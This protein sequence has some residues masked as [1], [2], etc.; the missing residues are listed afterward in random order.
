M[1]T[2]EW[3]ED[4]ADSWRDMLMILV[5]YCYMDDV[6]FGFGIVSADN[7]AVVA[8]RNIVTRVDPGK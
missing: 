5:G 3:Q 4:I 6:G 1:K 8:G 7:S 2:A